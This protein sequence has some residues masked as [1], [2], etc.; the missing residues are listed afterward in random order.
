MTRNIGRGMDNDNEAEISEADADAAIGFTERRLAL[1]AEL[2]AML[3]PTPGN[4]AYLSHRED[5]PMTDDTMSEEETKEV[6]R[7][8]AN[9]SPLEAK[10]ELLRQSIRLGYIGKES[11]GLQRLFNT[12]DAFIAGTRTGWDE[13]NTSIVGYIRELQ[14][15]PYHPRQDRG[16]LCW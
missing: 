8:Y 13:N 11:V 5:R 12:I 3:T 4:R 14:Q 2:K 10:L 15:R 9:M 6:Q 7:R 1:R 16:E